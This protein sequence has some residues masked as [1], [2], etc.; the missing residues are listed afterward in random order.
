M[1]LVIRIELIDLFV[2]MCDRHN[3]GAIVKNIEDRS[4]RCEHNVSH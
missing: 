1:W 2:R 4:I 3:N